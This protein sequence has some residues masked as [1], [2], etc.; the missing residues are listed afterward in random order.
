MIRHR[1]L[2]IIFMMGCAAV[3]AGQQQRPAT[4]E[5]L[6]V[7]VESNAPLAATAVE[8]RIDSAVGIRT[9]TDRNGN[10]LFANVGAGDYRL[11]ATR[12][13]YVR[14]E[15]APL[16]P[17]LPQRLTVGTGQTLK[18]LRLTMTRGSVIAGRVLD[19]G[20]PVV[21]VHV[22]VGKI[23]YESGAPVWKKVLSSQTNDQGE[24][25]IFWLPP[26]RYYVLA[27]FTD[28]RRL[29]PP[30]I[31]LNPGGGDNPLLSRNILQ[32]NL[33]RNEVF[34]PLF[35]RSRTGGGVGDA[36]MHVPMYFPRTPDWHDA[37]AIDI[38]PGAQVN[39]VDIDASPV[40]A[41]HVRGVVQGGPFTNPQGRPLAPT[42]ALFPADSPSPSAVAFAQADSNGL[43]DIP[44]IPRGSYVLRATAGGLTGLIDLDIRDRDANGVTVALGPGRSLSGRVVFEEGTLRPEQILSRLTVGVRRNSVDQFLRSSRPTVDGTFTIQDIPVGNYQVFVTPV[45]PLRAPVE[46]IS[47]PPIEAQNETFQQKLVQ[48]VGAAVPAA[49][50]NV[51]V[52]S[53]TMGATDVMNNGVSLDSPASVSSLVITLGTNPGSIEGR[54]L[55][56]GPTSAGATVVLIPEAGQRRHVHHRFTSSDESGRFRFSNVPPG[57][58]K[59]FSWEHVERGAWEN[60]DFLREHESRG[61]LVRVVE[62]QQISA[63]VTLIR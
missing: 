52:K 60:E 32:A 33:E 55:N 3:L 14:S 53:M 40:A 49:L 25:R 30:V 11:L 18:G 31:F 20:R 27:D 62:Q 45:R 39:N 5:G 59:L 19:R 15:Y 50:A 17:D 2:T 21:K 42:V 10:F 58:Y 26:G 24:Y 46:P 16:K 61:V 54:V 22:A 1:Q 8:L 9:T 37:T 28:I 56:G 35:V 23:S 12:S 13:G 29:P 38:A 36:E 43:F 7:D 48:G 4:L 51:Y 6:V 63:D 57:E 41:L 34:A 47:A 44:R